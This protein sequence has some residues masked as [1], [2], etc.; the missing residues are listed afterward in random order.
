[1]TYNGHHH[2]VEPTGADGVMIL[3]SGPY[4]IG[5]S[6]RIRLDL[7]EHCASAQKISQAFHRH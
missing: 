3:G 5:S 4:R 2:D 7:S 6:G 1:M